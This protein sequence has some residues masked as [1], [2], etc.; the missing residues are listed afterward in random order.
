MAGLPVAG[1]LW[2]A[3][4]GACGGIAAPKQG[5]TLE[6]SLWG[7]E[8]AGRSDGTIYLAANVH[9]QA[10]IDPDG[11]VHSDTRMGFLAISAIV[12]RV[13]SDGSYD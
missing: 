9:G 7:V 1:G 10:N 4:V 6:S 5:D 3:L 12:R 8:L 11:T 13:R 2:M